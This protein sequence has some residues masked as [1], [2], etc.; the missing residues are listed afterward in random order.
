MEVQN[1]LK[2]FNQIILNKTFYKFIIFVIAYIPISAHAAYQGCEAVNTAYIEDDLC[3]VE[4]TNCKENGVTLTTSSDSKLVAICDVKH[5]VDVCP[6]VIP[7]PEWCDLPRCPTNPNECAND[8]EGDGVTNYTNTTSPLGRENNDD[9]KQE[10]QANAD[11]IHSCEKTGE[12]TLRDHK[13]QMEVTGCKRGDLDVIPPGH[14]AT[15]ACSIQIG[16]CNRRR[17]PSCVAYCPTDSN[18]CANDDAD[19]NND[20][21]YINLEAVGGG[22]VYT[23]DWER[24]NRISPGKGSN[25]G[26]TGI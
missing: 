26:G 21:N 25:Q 17:P 10:D 5:G 6:T 22:F 11:L 18:E 19:D 8:N 20:N 13:C 3:K 24:R 7:R 12:T 16:A 15:A 2:L 9:A 1:N 14:T 4:V 23:P